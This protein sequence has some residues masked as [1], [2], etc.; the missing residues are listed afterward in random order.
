[1]TIYFCLKT[2][3]FLGVEHTQSRGWRAGGTVRRQL[4]P[5]TGASQ[6]PPHTPKIAI[7]QLRGDKH[8]YYRPCF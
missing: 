1:M 5:H 2:T 4:Q 7:P 6:S 3:Q 8:I